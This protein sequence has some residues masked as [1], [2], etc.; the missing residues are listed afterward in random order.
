MKIAIVGL[1][2]HPIAEPFAGGMESHTWWLAKKL[3]ERGHEVTLFA[4]GDSDKSLGLSAC[5][6]SSLSSH[7]NA[8]SYF[9]DMACNM[10]AYA[11]VLRRICEGQFDIVHN[12]ALHPLLLLS[13]ADLPVPM[14]M[15]L[16]AIVSPELAAAMH[17][18]ATR[19]TDKRLKVAAVSQSVADQW[20]SIIETEVVYNGIDIDSWPFHTNPVKNMALWYG[21]FVPE[22]APH[23]AIQAALA[24]N[25]S[26]NIA[27][28]VSDHAYFD[29]QILPLLTYPEVT[30]LGHLSH[31]EIK[32]L[33]AQASVF[34]NTPMWEE[35]YGIVYAEALAT[36]VPVVAFD[37]GAASEILNERCGVVV[38]ESTIEALATGIAQAAKLSR[39]SCRARA[40]SF[41]SLNSMVDSYECLYHQLI[42]K[43]QQIM[44]SKQ[45]TQKNDITPTS[46][47]IKIAS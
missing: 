43:Q 2:R 25:Y 20:R 16:H 41:C 9:G 42:I 23:L 37:R 4:S 11:D 38:E 36:G 6:K 35:P 31:L 24:A 7:P 26:I 40:E 28:P 44:I 8:Q 18:A 30:Y 3:I 15:V 13:A 39:R 32:Q 17:Y 12:N 46:E 19:N 10:T 14:L 22:K 29:D 27:G 1:M 34:V 21:R 33:L 5:T 45:P 47:L